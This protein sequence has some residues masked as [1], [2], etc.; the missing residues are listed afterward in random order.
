M[1]VEYEDAIAAV[2]QLRRT[3]EQPPTPGILASAAQEIERRRFEE[4]RYRQRKLVAVPT[5]DERARCKAQL[6]ELIETFGQ[7]MA[8]AH[9][10]E[11]ANE[12]DSGRSQRHR[13]A[14]AQGDRG[15]KSL[16]SGDC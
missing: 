4:R 6:R 13:S 8:G 5:A 1:L 11:T 3:R 16:R 2:I 7:Q 15:I 10:A 12:E 9:S 14:R